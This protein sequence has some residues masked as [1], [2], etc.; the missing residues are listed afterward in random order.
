MVNQH[1]F[2][3]LHADY[4]GQSGRAHTLQQLLVLALEG[5]VVVASVQV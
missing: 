1:S 4:V 3:V 2:A 5:P